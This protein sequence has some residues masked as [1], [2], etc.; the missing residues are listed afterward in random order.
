M[1][2]ILTLADLQRDPERLLDEDET[3]GFRGCSKATMQRDRWAG[4]GIPYVK[5]GRKARY[6]ARDVLASVMAT[7][8]Q[9]N[10]G[11]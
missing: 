8:V 3:A 10:Q 7:R 6:L 9:T 2:T 4:T 11:T 5:C 1:Q